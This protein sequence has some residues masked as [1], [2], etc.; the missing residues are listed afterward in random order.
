MYIPAVNL[1]DDKARIAAF[2]QSHGFA[3]LA[4]QKDGKLWAS[5]LPILFDEMPNGPGLLRG[6]M[7]RANEQWR[8]FSPGQEV[9]C[10]F[11]GPHAYISPSWYRTKELVP[12]WNYA[13]IHVYGICRIPDDE[14]FLIKILKDTT[15]KYESRMTPPWA[16]ESVSERMSGLLKAIVGFT[17]EITR[18]EAKFK[19]GQ[20]REPEDRLGMLQGLRQSNS[21]ANHELAAFIVDQA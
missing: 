11:Q 16:F 18:I 7:A 14:S 12:T 13:A 10:I 6:H 2:L 9:L 5:H 17:I 20:N 21:P 3:T 4:T 1:V 8:H 19:L 15:D